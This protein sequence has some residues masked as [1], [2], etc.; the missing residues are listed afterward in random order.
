MFDTDPSSFIFMQFSAIF[1]Q[2]T[3]MHSSR[4]HTAH[5][6]PYKGGGGSPDRDPPE[7]LLGRDPPPWTAIPPWTDK[8]PVKTLPSQTSLAGG[9]NLADPPE[10]G[11]PSGKS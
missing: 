6:L 1:F 3:R 9:N 8:P 10:V 4:M 5:S 11:A 7:T 2:I